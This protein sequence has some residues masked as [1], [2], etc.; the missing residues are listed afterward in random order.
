MSNWLNHNID[1][2][3][4][5]K[6]SG[7]TAAGLVAAGC[8]LTGE[9]SDVA[10]ERTDLRATLPYPR[11]VV[12]RA[13]EL[14]VDKPLVFSYPDD[15]SPCAVLKTGNPTPGGV[16]PDG[17]IVAYSTQCPHMGMPLSYDPEAR[18]FKCFKHFSIYDPEALGQQVC[19]QST[20]NMPRVQL[21]Y[22]GETDELLAI[23]VAGLIYG[24][25]SNII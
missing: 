6:F 4:F 11:T 8:A 12:A 24:R 5:L 13:T 14:E 15:Q 25:V 2:R 17:D 7:G 22:D 3:R 21:D 10:A 18:T 23:G 19:G 20:E 1:R 9:E 16:G